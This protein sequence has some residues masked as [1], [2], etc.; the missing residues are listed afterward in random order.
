MAGWGR[1]MLWKGKNKNNGIVNGTVLLCVCF[2]ITLVTKSKLTY[3]YVRCEFSLISLYLNVTEEDSVIWTQTHCRYFDLFMWHTLE[4]SSLHTKYYSG[5]QQNNTLGQKGQWKN[6]TK[7]RIW[8]YALDLY[9][10]SCRRT[11]ASCKHHSVT[12]GCIKGWRSLPGW[13]NFSM[14]ELRISFCEL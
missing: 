10:T 8:R 13:V 9:D 2:I 12:L 5:N 11:T 1:R 7:S 6:R 3:K 4:I 14:Y